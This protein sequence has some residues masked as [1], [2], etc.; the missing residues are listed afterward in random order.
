MSADPL[1]LDTLLESVADGNSLDWAALEAAADESQRRLIRHLRVVAGV[2]EV[3]RTMPAIDEARSV[4]LLD[5]MTTGQALPRW[6]H[7]V[8]LEKIGE[9][10]FGEVYRARDPWLDREVALKLLRPEVADRVPATRLVGEARTLARVRHPNVVS[11]YGADMH[12]GRVGLWMELVRGRTLAQIVAAQGAFSAS[13]AAVIGQEICRALA[14]VHAAGLVHRDVKAQNVM[15]EAGG[16]LVLM[17]FGAGQ[18]PLYVAPELL[19]GGDASVSGDIYALG[20]LLY[21]L[22][23]GKYPVTGTSIDELRTAHA[24]GQVRH[25][26]EVRPDLPDNF[27]AAVTRALHPDPSRRY[28]TARQMQDALARITSPGTSRRPAVAPAAPA[29]RRARRTLLAAAALLVAALGAGGFWLSR[30]REAPPV[31]RGDATWLA[32]LPFRHIGPDAV[33]AYYGDGLSEDLTA[34]LSTLPAVRL[35]SGVSVRRYRNTDRPA[36]EIGRELNVSA[37]VTG[38]VRVV[39]DRVRIVVELVDTRKSEQLWAGTFDRSLEDVL[40]IQA[41]VAQQVA[42]ALVGSLSPRDA[43]KLDRREQDPRAF[44][45]YLK[46]RYQWNTRT[47]EG[48]RQSIDLFRQAIAI[49]PDAALPYAGLADAYLLTAFYN[50]GSRAEAHDEAESAAAKAVS[51][52]PELAQAHAALGALRLTQF[53]WVG[54]ESSLK[55]AVELNPSYA[56]ARHWYALLLAQ[57]GRFDEAAAEIRAARAADPYS[58]AIHSA[59]GY[60]HLVSRSFDRAIDEYSQVLEA[61]PAN[62]Q[63]HIGLIEVHVARRASADALRALDAAE[64]LTGQSEQLSSVA[65]YVYALARDFDRSRSLLSQVEANFARAPGSAADVASVHAA[66]GDVDLAFEWLQR[67]VAQRDPLLGYLAVDPRF[68]PLRNDPRFARFL[69]QVGLGAVER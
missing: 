9:G 59:A 32:V 46:G 47:P 8:L 52:E 62:L 23:T 22:V 69:S 13:E 33:T 3:H 49:D 17:D 20:V 29:P 26:G 44:D 58:D 21:Y 11:V 42:Q 54:A 41:E 12:D 55:R 61:S 30:P 60:V 1:R 68:D 4:P 14:A 35:V 2:A 36:S 15:R 50:L 24:R 65:A 64:R 37:L 56:S 31:E 57:R 40:A 51:L 28:T 45:L 53:E 6:G 7:L 67:A 18:T 38:S 63:A 48:L 27:I 25:L 19:Q 34:Q 39:D 16:R 5:V 66:L 43:A 10:A